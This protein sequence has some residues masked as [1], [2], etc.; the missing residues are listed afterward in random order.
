MNLQDLLIS[1]KLEMFESKLI[2]FSREELY[3]Q[4]WSTSTLQLSKKFGISDVAIAKICKKHKIPKPSLGYWNMSEK[5]QADMKKPLSKA[6]GPEE[7]IKIYTK[8]IKEE[9]ESAPEIKAKLAEIAA[10]QILIPE[11]LRSLHPLV[12][13][14]WESLRKS[15]P[16]DYG[17]MW[18]R[19]DGCFN[20]AVGSK[21]IER[22]TKILDALLKAMAVIDFKISTSGQY[23]R[24]R[25]TRVNVLG[26]DIVFKL[27][28][29]A[30]G[31]SRSPTAEEKKW[32][33][34]D[35][36]VYTPSGKLNLI[37]DTYG[38]G[39]KTRW[40]DTE[41]HP[42][43]SQLRAFLEGLVR[44]AE[45]EKAS[46]ARRAEQE[47]QWKEQERL[48][49]EAEE[50][51]RKEAEKI[52]ELEAMAVNWDKSKKIELFL[53]EVERRS[54]E[55][56]GKQALDPEL[57]RWLAWARKHAASLDPLKIKNEDK[58]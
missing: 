3:E 44:V 58:N 36:R 50:L 49:R 11:N 31:S 8:I 39:N 13:K 32:G 19:E 16:D 47:R 46:N 30:I 7:K 38:G 2:T 26:E 40:T 21:N 37:V 51:R 12:K 33:Y 24:E 55:A 34:A 18:P 56:N 4:V 15:S 9:P 28:E 52:R 54:L 42:I 6:D 27:E 35:R 43:E 10:L 22:A 25:S 23:K 41:K 48:A 20:V 29:P 17:R 53:N 1:L 57:E 45:Y 5:D 14:T